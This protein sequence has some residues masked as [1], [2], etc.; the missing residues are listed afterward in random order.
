VSGHYFA[1]VRS[2]RG[3][4]IVLNDERIA[5]IEDLKAW[6]CNNQRNVLCVVCR[7]TEYDQLL[8]VNAT[9]RC[10]SRRTECVYGNDDMI[11]EDLQ[12]GYDELLN[13][14]MARLERQEITVAEC[15]NL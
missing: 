5:E 7:K 15:L 2:L 14:L 8:R 12:F 9:V 1:V 4:W 13:E 10:M 11:E 6:L 3:T